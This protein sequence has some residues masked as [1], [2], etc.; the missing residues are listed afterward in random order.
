MAPFCFFFSRVHAAFSLLL[1]SP[2]VALTRLFMHH[3][4]ALGSLLPIRNNLRHWE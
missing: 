1:L 3:L 4:R 2:Q